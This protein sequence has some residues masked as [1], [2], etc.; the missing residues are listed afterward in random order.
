M[1]TWLTTIFSVVI[2]LGIFAWIGLSIYQKIKQIRGKKKEKKEIEIKEDK[3]M[4]GMYLTTAFNFLTAPT[5]KTMTEGMTGI[6]TGLTS[7]LWKVKEGITNIL[8]EIMVFLGEVW[9]ILIPFAIFC[10]IKIL[11]F[12]RVMV[13]GF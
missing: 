1:P 10:I 7:S 8:P 5:S 4:L 2:I 12:F 11:N 13:K 6:W 9:I 3:K